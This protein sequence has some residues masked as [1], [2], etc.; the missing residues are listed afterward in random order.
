MKRLRDIPNGVMLSLILAHGCFRFPG[1]KISREWFECVVHREI[2]KG[3]TRMAK[4]ETVFLHIPL[5]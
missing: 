2:A 5:Q 4:R 1:D 3:R